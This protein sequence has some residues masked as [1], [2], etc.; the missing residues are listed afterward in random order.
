MNRK[1]LL[2]PMALLVPLVGCTKPADGDRSA[3]RDESAKQ[4][5]VTTSKDESSLQSQVKQIIT[6][7]LQVDADRVTL[8]ARLVDDLHADSLE[9]GG[10]IKAIEEV[11]NIEIPDQAAGVL[12]TVD[13]VCEY[14]RTAKLKPPSSTSISAGTGS[15][16]TSAPSATGRQTG[17]VNWFNDRKGYGFIRSDAG[18][19]VFVH[20]TEIKGKGF[21][22]LS[23]RQRVEFDIVSGMNGLRAVNVTILTDTRP[24]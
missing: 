1:C 17:T 6:G 2:L 4:S 7:E 11:F 8:Q 5:Q 13:D 22:A 15:P 18:G 21:K 3:K 10:L 19:D 16:V 9:V 14:V 20:Y 23:E 12:T 24:K